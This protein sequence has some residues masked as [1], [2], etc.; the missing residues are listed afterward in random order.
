MLHG[1]AELVYTMRMTKTY[2][3]DWNAS[4][5]PSSF[6]KK[7]SMPTSDLAEAEAT[8]NALVAQGRRA[9]LKANHEIIRDSGRQS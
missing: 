7:S 4:T 1:C 3:V 9:F 6:M 2:W 5:D 8:F